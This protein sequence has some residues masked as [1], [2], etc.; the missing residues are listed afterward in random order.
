MKYI[1]QLVFPVSLNFILVLGFFFQV[2]LR[3]IIYWQ[4]VVCMNVRVNSIL[5]ILEIKSKIPTLSLRQLWKLVLDHHLT[6]VNTSYHF[7][8]SEFADPWNLTIR[9]DVKSKNKKNKSVT[10]SNVLKIVFT[11]SVHLVSYQIELCSHQ[12]K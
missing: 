7:M 5:M 1:G 8:Y 11:N 2:H 12:T 3:Q 6:N 4:I 9:N 10:F